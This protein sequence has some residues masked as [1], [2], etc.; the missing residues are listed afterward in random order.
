MFELRGQ[1]TG[2]DLEDWLRAEAEFLHPVPLEIQK[3]PTKVTVQAQ[4]P[5][6]AVDELQVSVEPR[7]I[8]IAGQHELGP[9]DTKMI[10]AGSSPAELFCVID[11]PVE[12]IPEAAEVKL[13]GNTLHI[14]V[15]TE[16]DY[17]FVEE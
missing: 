7:R 10:C 12:V 1:Q 14:E 5:V 3:F 13:Q 17:G 2:H 9:G 4:V 15:P 16:V 8:L 6:S 11:L